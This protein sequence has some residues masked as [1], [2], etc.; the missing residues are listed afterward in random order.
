LLKSPEHIPLLAKKCINTTADWLLRVGD[1]SAY[2]PRR[3]QG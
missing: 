1:A 3:C 2:D